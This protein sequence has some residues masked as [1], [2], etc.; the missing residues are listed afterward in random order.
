MNTQTDRET[1]DILKM[2]ED[3]NYFPA[4]PAHRKTVAV[5]LATV[6]L[7]GK[8]LEYVPEWVICK[9]FEGRLICR[10]ALQAKDRCKD[11]VLKKRYI[12]VAA[13]NKINKR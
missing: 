3:K 11:E 9:E 12:F 5:S 13:E 7:C 8:H 10:A 2:T 6:S 1:R 4:L